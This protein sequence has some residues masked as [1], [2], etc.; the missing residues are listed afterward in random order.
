ME[1]IKITLKTILYTAF[2]IINILSKT[3][4]FANM[5]HHEA[6]KCVRSIQYYEQQYNIPKGLLHSIALIESGRWNEKLKQTQPWPWAVNVQGEAHYFQN[7]SSAISFVKSKQ[8]A[9]IKNIDIGCTQ[10]SLL[11]H[12]HKFPDL[13][14]AFE[15]VH[16]T[17]YAAE[18]LQAK[19]N[20]S[21]N[22]IMA[23]GWYHSKTPDNYIPY[24]HK[25]HKKWHGLNGRQYS[26]HNFAPHALQPTPVIPVT[27]PKASQPSAYKRSM[28]KDNSFVFIKN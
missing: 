13:D 28:R 23:I 4:A 3:N 24:I 16:N 1:K 17:R 18:F 7:K 21:K 8:R 9:G 12:G 11:H 15:P 14:T 19:H 20:E 6:Q 22:W 5:D 27:K 2:C 10:I 26:N 25:V